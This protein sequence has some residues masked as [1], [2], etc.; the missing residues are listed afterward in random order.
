MNTPPWKVDTF[1]NAIPHECGTCAP[2]IGKLT[3]QVPVF[4]TPGERSLRDCDAT[5]SL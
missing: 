1:A 3:E 5:P 2:Q 4:H